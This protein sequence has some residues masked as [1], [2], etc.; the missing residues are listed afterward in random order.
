M[1][2]AFSSRL[3]IRGTLKLDSILSLFKCITNKDGQGKG[4]VHIIQNFRVLYVFYGW[5]L[6]EVSLPVSLI[7]SLQTPKLTHRHNSILKPFNVSASRQGKAHSNIQHSRP[8]AMSVTTF[9]RHSVVGI[10]FF[11][12]SFIHSL[13]GKSFKRLLKLAFFSPLLFH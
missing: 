7:D 1:M 9:N 8:P 4:L 12:H 13:F 3:W 6:R 5:P 11:I 10:Y 2:R